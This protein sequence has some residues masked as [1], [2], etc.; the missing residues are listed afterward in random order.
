[1]GAKSSA[2][3]LG[4][5]GGG[6]ASCSSRRRFCR[7]AIDPSMFGSAL[8]SPPPHNLGLIPPPGVHPGALEHCHC[9]RRA[10]ACLTVYSNTGA[11]PMHQTLGS[12]LMASH[13]PTK[14]CSFRSP[15]RPALAVHSTT[16]A[17]TQTG[18]CGP[19]SPVA[20]GISLPSAPTLCTS[21]SWV[22]LALRTQPDVAWSTCHLQHD[23]PYPKEGPHAGGSLRRWSSAFGT[24]LR[25]PHP[26]S[27][28]GS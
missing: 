28:G 27:C 3:N 23:G 11:A 1:M 12:T 22:V 19:G 20:G 25:S 2:A 16:H 13:A 4:C 7:V 9:K 14:N 18:P 15:A 17:D 6:A 26:R 8:P 10:V 5:R 21:H 24:S